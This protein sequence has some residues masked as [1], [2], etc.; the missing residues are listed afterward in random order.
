[1][2]FLLEQSPELFLIGD[3]QQPSAESLLSLPLLHVTN[4]MVL[5]QRSTFYERDW[6]PFCLKKDSFSTVYKLVRR[7]MGSKDYF[8]LIILF[9]IASTYI[10]E[11]DLNPMRCN[12]QFHVTNILY[13]VASLFFFFCVC[14]SSLEVKAKA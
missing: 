4:A 5:V 14:F 7:W 13:F 12:L 11:V 1:M 6:T 2:V 10:C 9:L 8:I 3:I